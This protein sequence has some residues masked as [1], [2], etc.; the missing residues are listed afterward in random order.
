VG[1]CSKKKLDKEVP[2]SSSSACLAKV[3]QSFYSSS[4]C[5]SF[6]QNSW[7]TFFSIYLYKVIHVVHSENN[8]EYSKPLQTNKQKKKKKKKTS[9][10][11]N[12]Q[13]NKYF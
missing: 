11:T 2:D 1:C 5:C 7:Y 3:F 13:T 10:Q 6:E 9:K 8:I 4:C 12:K